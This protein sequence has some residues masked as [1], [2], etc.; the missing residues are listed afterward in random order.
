MQL[1]EFIAGMV[2]VTWALPAKSGYI[3]TRLAIAEAA[4]AISGDGT[5]RVPKPGGQAGPKKVIEKG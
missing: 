3:Q 5:Q 2:F 4:A 1:Q